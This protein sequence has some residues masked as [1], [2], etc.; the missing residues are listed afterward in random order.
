MAIDSVITQICFAFDDHRANGGLV[1]SQIVH[2][3]AHFL[4]FMFPILKEA[5]V[6]PL[7]TWDCDFAFNNN[8]A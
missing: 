5:S 6:A 3:A 4:C 7:C 1:K 2:G 8:L